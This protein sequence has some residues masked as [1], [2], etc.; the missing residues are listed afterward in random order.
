MSTKPVPIQELAVQNR[1]MLT[2]PRLDPVRSQNVRSEF[3][4]WFG[5]FTCPQNLPTPSPAMRDPGSSRWVR[6]GA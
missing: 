1:P 6:G 5:K 4:P 2:D 3:L